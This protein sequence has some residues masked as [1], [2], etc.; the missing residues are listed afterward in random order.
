MKILFLANWKV[1]FLSEDNPNIQSPDKL[2]NGER[3][4][5]FKYWDESVMIDIIDF[6]RL[7]FFHH[8]EK[9]F[10]KFYIFQSIIAMIRSKKYDVII[11]HGAQSAVFLAFIRSIF[12]QKLPPLLLIDVGCFNGGRDNKIETSLIKFLAKSFSGIIYHAS[13][14]KEYYKK[15]LPFLL[16]KCRFIP[17]GVDSDFFQPLINKKENYVVSIGYAKRDYNTLLEAWESLSILKKPKL[18]II[19]VNDPRRLGV[20]K[21]HPAVEFIGKIPISEL[22]YI[23]S[24]SIFVIMPLPYYRYA[25]G[26]MTVL[27]SMSMGKAVIVT[28]VPSIMDYISDGTDALFIKPYNVADMRSKIEYLLDNPNIINFIEKNARNTVLKKFN[29]KIMAKNIYDFL[30]ECI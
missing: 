11:A 16:P 29:E 13:I 6:I 15:H 22:K 28:K 7:P 23:V 1:Y 14:Q 8:F 24:K 2:V 26:Q 12:K 5:F 20:S 9:K 30:K 27:Q 4:W 25:L 17:F 21:I 18:I 3:Y 19:G 10:L